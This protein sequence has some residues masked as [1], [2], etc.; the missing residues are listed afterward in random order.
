MTVQF[1]KTEHEQVYLESLRGKPLLSNINM[2][3]QLRFVKLHLNK[4]QDW[5]NVLWTDETKV[6]MCGH[7]AH[8]ETRTQHISTLRELCINKCL[9]IS[10]N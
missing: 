10:M 3:A 1:E 7:N 2:A 8:C 6:E 4:P 9:Q 5:S